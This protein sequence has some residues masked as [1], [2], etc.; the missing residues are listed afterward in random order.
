[1]EMKC[2]LLTKLTVLLLL[3]NTVLYV[4]C[5]KINIIPT[6]DSPCPGAARGEHCFTLQQYCDIANL[7]LSPNTTLKFYPGNHYMDSKLFVSKVTSFTM[8]ATKTAFNLMQSATSVL[9][10]F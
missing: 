1:M 2:L 7:S 3:D 6:P 9:V 4:S 5:D 8:K 10:L